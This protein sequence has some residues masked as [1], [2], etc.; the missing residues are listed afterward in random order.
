MLSTFRPA[1]GGVPGAV[2]PN[3]SACQTGSCG[4]PPAGSPSRCVD[5][6]CGG[7]TGA[8]RQA[9]EKR[10]PEAAPALRWGAAMHF[11][12]EHLGTTTPF[13]LGE[14][15]HLLG[16]GPE[17]H[18]QL[19][20]LPPGFLALRIEGPRLTVEAAE[21]FSVNEV[22]VPPGVAR[23][24]LPGEVLGLPEEMRLRVLAPAS[25]RSVGTVAV[26]KG[27]LLDA[28]AAVPASRAA[29]LTCLTGLDVGRTFPL[30]EARTDLGRGTV[31][32][33]RL[34]D[35]AVSRLHARILR[36][37]NAFTL[38]DMESPNG[39]Y[40]NGHRVEEPAPL[41]DGDVIELGQT[42]LRFQAAVEEPPPPEPPKVELEPPVPGAEA[43][44]VE[45]APAPAVTAPVDAASA[46]AVQA[47]PGKRR[48]EWWLMGLG[49]M[50]ALVGLLVTYALA[51]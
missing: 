18:V 12:F 44:S 35:R 17:D 50:L 32:D 41:S 43:S 14:G 7:R 22:R 30:A 13:E 1:S 2:L 37:G 20:G 6:G 9:R 5:F 16:G 40:V 25:E 42:L 39:I 47:L 31:A 19:T 28:E 45:P 34:R 26:L 27:L 48:G 21:T 36:E 38:Q 15:Q 10:A 33:I 46:P 11:E 29:T 49:A 23:L 51:G 8:A 4:A 24:V 3:L